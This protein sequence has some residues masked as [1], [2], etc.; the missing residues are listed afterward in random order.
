MAGGR[1]KGCQGTC[2]KD[3]WTKPNWGRIESGRWGRLRWV[4]VVRRK[5]R[6]LYLNNNFFKLKNR[7]EGIINCGM[8]NNRILCSNGCIQPIILWL[9]LTKAMLSE[10]SLT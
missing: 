1:G 4:G 5:W 7:V 8:L 2:R 3:T 9:K 10:R 6:Q